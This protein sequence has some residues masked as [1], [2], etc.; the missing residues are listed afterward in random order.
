MKKI[1]LILVITIFIFSAFIAVAAF[2]YINRDD[3]TT[4]IEPNKKFLPN[5]DKVNEINIGMEFQEVID[6][7][8]KPQ[9][10]SGS[11]VIIY[12][13]DLSNG[14]VLRTWWEKDIEKENQYMNDNPNAKTY[15]S[16]FLI[17]NKYEIE[18]KK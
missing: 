8:G 6:I 3:V 5:E 13:F 16:H 10:Q 12:E 11:G 15:G 18:T 7:L 17:L 1:I 2:S 9:R 4:F 14:K